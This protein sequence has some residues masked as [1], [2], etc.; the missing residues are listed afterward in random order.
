MRPIR[1]D[2]WKRWTDAFHGWRD[3]RAGIPARLAK[4]VPA[5]PVTTPHREALIRQAQD[6]FTYEHLEYHRLVAGPHRRIMAERA[7]LKASQATLTWAKLAFDMESR[8]LTEQETRRRRLGEEHHPETVIVR[9]RRKEHHKLLARAQAA[10]TR[11]EADLAAMEADLAQAMEEAKQ[12]HEAAVI[13]VERIHEHIHRRLAVYRRALVRAHPEGAWANAVLSVRAPEIPGWALPD[14]YLP[15][16][17]PQSPESPG[18]PEPPEPPEP[19]EPPVRIIELQQEVTRFGSDKRVDPEGEIGYVTLDAPVAAPW[20]FTVVKMDGLLHLQTR[21]YGHGP[22][23]GGEAVGTA[24]L[25]PGGFFDFAD[26]RYTMLDADRLEDAPLG[27]CDLIAAG[28]SATSGSKPRL[29]EMSFVQREK[30]LLAVLGPSGAGKSSLFEALIGEL[31]L[32]SGRLY[33]RGMSMATNSKQIREQ[34]GFVPQETELHKSLTVQATLRYGFRLRSPGGKKQQ[35]DAINN[36]LTVLKLDGQRNQRL[37]TL[38]GGQLRRVSIALELL[39]DPPLLLLDEPTSGLDASMDRQ[40]MKFL[41]D[42]A[43]GGRRKAGPDGASEG[44][45]V[46]VTTHTTEHLAMARQILVVVEDGAPAYSGPRR[47]IRRH[48]HFQAY[49][50]L[51]DKLFKDPRKWADEYR[52]GQTAKEAIR[53]ADDLERK[54]ATGPSPV[55][56]VPQK[57]RKRTPGAVR[58]RLGV[59]GVLLVR[60]CVLLRSRALTKNTPHRT[61][62]D[63]LHNGC[64]VSLPLIIAAGSAALAA[65]VAAAPGLGATPSGGGPTALALLTTL[66]VLSGQA[67][68]YSDVVNELPIIRR[69]FRAGVGALPVLTAKWLIYAVIAVVQA[70]LITMVFCLFANRAPQRWVFYNPEADLF[71]SLAALSVAAMTL[72]LL[73]SAMATKLEHA[74]ALVTATSIAQ[75]ALNGVTANLHKTSPTSIFAGLL[76]D[77]WGLAAA[78]SSVDLRGINQGHVTQV[79][80]DALWRHSSGQWFQ[81]LAA[82]ALLS[83]VYFAMAVWR[84]HSRLRPRKAPSRDRLHRRDGLLQHPSGAK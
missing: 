67:L 77:R 45:T 82:L 35:D 71:L 18:P 68:T 31:P 69:E 53:E 34:L 52:D 33:F 8:A 27:K 46:I 28:V 21:G 4:P 79:S 58:H 5:G 41:R 25:E 19:V 9:R 80:A 55:G 81:D 51:M 6:A 3:G 57:A 75:I 26:R 11:A 49:A 39:T 64:V 43:K 66:C 12:H 20:H 36:A 14:A 61:W 2:Q 60:Q 78:A 47:D 73:V 23:I 50:D 83:A 37:S 1:Y 22:Y 65:L 15:D 44:H 40:I 76:P 63:R 72:G 17:V 59:L 10:V 84:L 29:S 70:G 32:Q 16:T 74:V 13:R 38:S 42:H 30:T 56:N 48:F 62:L 24:V 54:L 7:R